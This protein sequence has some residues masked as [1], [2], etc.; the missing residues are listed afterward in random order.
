MSE[1]PP[2]PSPALPPRVV[3]GADPGHGGTRG[4]SMRGEARR[5]APAGVD[6]GSIGTVRLGPRVID[7]HTALGPDAENTGMPPPNSVP[8]PTHEERERLGQRLACGA[9]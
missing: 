3:A 1:R 4:A 9:P 6:L 2:P 5:G 7:A 8:V